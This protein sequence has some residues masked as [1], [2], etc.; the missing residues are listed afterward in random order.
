MRFD[1]KEEKSFSVIVLKKQKLNETKIED[2]KTESFSLQ[3]E[4]NQQL[5]V[6]KKN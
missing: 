3:M 4:Y 5:N 6:T 1:F 2:L